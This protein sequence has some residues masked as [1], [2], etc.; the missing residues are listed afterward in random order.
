MIGFCSEGPVPATKIFNTI[1]INQL[2]VDAC[3]FEKN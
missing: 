1:K 2:H 3:N